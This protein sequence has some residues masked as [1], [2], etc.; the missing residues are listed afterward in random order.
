MT[1]TAPPRDRATPVARTAGPLHG[2]GT[3]VRLAVRRDRVL[4]PIWILAFAAMAAFSVA[5]TRDLYP[6]E[7][8]LVAASDVI[9][10]TAALVALYGKIYVP[11]SLG[12]VSL[13]KMT[14]FGAALVAVLFVFLVVRHT[15]SEEETGR[16]ELVS[17]GAVGRDAP[18]AA[19]L[20]VGVGAGVAVGLI[21]AASLVAVG[22]PL[23]GSV[24]FGLAWAASALVFTAV[25]AV[26]AQ[27]TTSARGALGLGLATVA[28]AYALRAIGD[29]AAGD[30]GVLSWLSPIGWSQQ[31]RPFAGDRW[32]VLAVPVAAAAAGAVVA[33]ILRS[34]RDLG[35]GY[36]P[37]RVG[38]AVG[39]V[40]GVTA[41][42][43]RLQRGTLVGWLVVAGLF[44]AA[45]G[46]VAHNVTG[47]FDSPQMRQY[48]VLLGGE[49]ALTDAFL[50]AE[51]A[52]MGV[53]VAAYGIGAVHRL[54]S[55]EAAGHAEFLLAD[56]TTRIRWALTHLTIALLGTALV[57][58][59]AGV[60]IG[61][62]HGLAVGSPG[63]QTWRMA[64]AA[65]TQVPA[66]WA[67]VAV[68]FLVFGWFPLATSGVWALYAACLVLGEFGA[69]WQLPDWILN[70]SPFAHSPTVP[71]GEVSTVA[72][73]TLVAVAAVI[74]TVGMV[75]W[76]RRDLHP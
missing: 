42:A 7:Q 35:S 70:L 46:S 65:A 57:L 21:T 54:R 67:M 26:A 69:L 40:G 53:I 1:I 14:A 56:G 30:P 47:F 39:R 28:V 63:V 34:H 72:L 24:A 55:E 64:A 58:I 74:V 25:G 29:L 18:L 45:L 36:L 49:Q 62:T 61:L 15:R 68:A 38:P 76:R 9:N 48:L 11:T 60:A 16:L 10:A 66:A 37:E 44:G 23:A 32:W 50:A 27:I 19:A 13:I 2:T 5:A 31:V 12:A 75:G 71:G 22:L 4:L 59:T 17:A 20:L 8:S 43:W 3:L 33:F 41:L 52:I 51:V 73:V 6:D